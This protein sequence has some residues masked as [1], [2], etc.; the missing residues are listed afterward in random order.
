[1]F[2]VVVEANLADVSRGRYRSDMRPHAALQS[3]IAF[4]VRHRVPFIWAGDRKGAE[5][6]TYWL[7]AKYLREIGEQHRQATRWQEEKK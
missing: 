3:I 6:I 2:A 1:L 5:Y 4:Q 7:L